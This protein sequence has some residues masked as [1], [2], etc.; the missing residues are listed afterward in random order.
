M[1]NFRVQ[2]LPTQMGMPSA[3]RIQLQSISVQ[4]QQM[5]LYNNVGNVGS[6]GMGGM[7]GMMGGIPVLIDTGH[8]GATLP[9]S[10]WNAIYSKS[11]PVKTKDA[12]YLI[13]CSQVS[14]LPALSLQFANSNP[15]VLQGFQQVL[16]TS[17]CICM[18]IFCPTRKELAMGSTFL[19]NFFTV[20]NYQDT[21]ISFYATNNQAKVTCNPNENLSKSSKSRG[22]YEGE[23]EMKYSISRTKVRQGYYTYLHPELLMDDQ[24]PINVVNSAT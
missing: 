5:P 3:W 13:D 22:T 14:A 11:N 7:N 20:F 17:D 9:E 19:S 10:V 1:F 21:S 6:G 24:T 15:I 23:Y 16:V 8:P 18:L 2:I 12:S 4:G